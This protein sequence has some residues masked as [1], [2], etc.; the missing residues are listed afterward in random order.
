MYGASG[1][2]VL[3]AVL[4]RPLVQTT[5]FLVAAAFCA[6]VIVATLKLSDWGQAAIFSAAEVLFVYCLAARRLQR[7]RA[8]RLKAFVVERNSGPGADSDAKTGESG[9][10]LL[11][12]F[13]AQ[14]PTALRRPLQIRL[15]AAA[16]A[17]AAFVVVAV[18]VTH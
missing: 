11:R 8:E 5:I 3:P 18:V 16:L 13:R 2:A 12:A 4:R 1:T 17:V 9:L 15:L 14:E 7:E 10:E 6:L